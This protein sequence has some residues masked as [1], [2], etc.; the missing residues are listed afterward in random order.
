MHVIALQLYVIRALPIR[1]RAFYYL[2]QRLSLNESD[3]YVLVF[4]LS[5]I[6][7]S[8]FVSKPSTNLC[9]ISVV[10]YYIAMF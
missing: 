1:P 2:C 10:L 5:I 9:H 3:A 6:Y 8:V 7:F 4:D